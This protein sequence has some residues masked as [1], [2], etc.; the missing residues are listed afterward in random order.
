MNPSVAGCL[1]EVQASV[2]ALA[3]ALAQPAPPSQLTASS[4]ALNLQAFKLM[5]LVKQT[6]S[7]ATQDPSLVRGLRQVAASLAACQAQMARQVALTNQA[8]QMLL[9][10]TAGDT[11]TSALQGR[12]GQPYGSAGRRSGEF[13]AISA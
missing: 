2:D 5:A 6:P 10:T 4:D 1:N 11:Y 8:L 12:S 7:V 3:K 13:R 9:P